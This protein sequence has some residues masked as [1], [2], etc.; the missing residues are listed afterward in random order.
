ME[1]PFP[2]NVH[3]LAYANDIQLVVTGMNRHIKAQS[4]H[5]SIESKC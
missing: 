5:D 3:L 4:A 2:A 1:I